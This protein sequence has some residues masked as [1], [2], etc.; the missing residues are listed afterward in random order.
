MSE[1]L[2]LHRHAALMCWMV[3]IIGTVV[4]LII[5][6]IVQDYTRLQ[7]L[8]GGTVSAAV[9]SQLSD[10]HQ[11]SSTT[12]GETDPLFLSIIQ[13]ASDRYEVEPELIQ[14]I[15]M[16]ESSYNPRAVSKRGARGLMQLMP[17]TA[18]SLGVE[19][20]F[21]PEHNIHGGVRYFKQ[22]LDRFGGDTKMAL[23][24]YNAGSRKV[25]QYQG[26]P[27]FKATRYYIKKVFSYYNRYKT[28]AASDRV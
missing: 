10:P 8:P 12:S 13:E 22:L 17:K 5:P 16:A 2:P 7:I 25:R 11:S 6:G 21:N 3:F 1:D 9:S 19:D 20:S 4:L 14:A 15:I 24:A 27:P 18:K 28:D 26:I 23:A